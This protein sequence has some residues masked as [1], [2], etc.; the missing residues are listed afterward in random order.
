[1]VPHS[2]DDVGWVKTVEE[3]FIGS[4]KRGKVESIID[5]AID[6]LLKDSRRKFTYTEMKF[7]TM[8]YNAQ[9]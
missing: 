2:H 3:Y 1:L 9:T 7:F 4:S 6:E 8:W 5:G